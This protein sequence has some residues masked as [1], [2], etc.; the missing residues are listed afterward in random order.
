MPPDPQS[1]G[2]VALAVPR[3]GLRAGSAA[4]EPIQG[5][6]GVPVLMTVDQPLDL[7][8]TLLSGQSFRW[9]RDAEWFEGVVF[10]NIVRM[11]QDVAGIEFTSAPDDESFVRPLV[12][13]YL[14][15][16]VDLEGIYA[17]I[18]ADDRLKAAIARYR[19]LRVL[20]QDPWECLVSFI[21]SSASNIP[22]ISSNIESICAAFGRE[23]R[24]GDRVRSTFPTP[25][26]LAEAG[27]ER[28]RRLG[29]G[30]RAPFIASTARAI[31][32]GVPD[33]MTLRE[34]PYEEALRELT[35]LDGVGDKVANCVLLFSLDKLEA[36]PVDVWVERALQ[37]WY[38]RGADKKLTRSKMRLWA[39]DYFGPY[40][41]YAN[42]YLFHDRRLQG[43]RRW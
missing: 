19:G 14:A 34:A 1:T 26:E 22:R 15:L 12:R 28:L 23:V 20:R 29:V 30:Y 31:A 16:E 21:C 39:R 38:L 9:Q 18:G 8:S 41:G 32:D 33:L 40:A 36:F 25:Q 2:L 17:S 43:R 27:E 7:A 3:V 35:A 5:R 11:R 10:N 42:Q 4:R 13:D 24:A 6:T 37:E